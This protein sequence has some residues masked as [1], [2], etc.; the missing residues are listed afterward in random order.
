M[1]AL[2]NRILKAGLWTLALLVP[3]LLLLTGLDALR[4]PARQV[5]VPVFAAA[6]DGY[7]HYL[8]PMTARFIRCRYKPTCS[9]YAVQAV[10]KYGIGKGGWMAVRRIAS[11]RSG[12]PLGTVDEVP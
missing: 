8:H 2:R 6:V 12:V 11:C 7:H 4:P 1:P 3:A 5:S 9:N 10:K